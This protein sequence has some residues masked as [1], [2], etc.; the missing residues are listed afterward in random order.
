MKFWNMNAIIKRIMI[1][2]LLCTIIFL[3]ISTALAATQKSSDE[4]TAIQEQRIYEFAL[5]HHF[6]TI[7][8]KK[9][10]VG[11]PYQVNYNASGKYMAI[12]NTDNVDI[13][14]ISNGDKI[15]SVHDTSIQHAEFSPDA[16]YIN[17]TYRHWPMIRMWNVQTGQLMKELRWV[18]DLS[19]FCDATKACQG[20]EFMHT[21]SPDGRYAALVVDDYGLKIWSTNYTEPTKILFEFDITDLRFDITGEHLATLK[22][23]DYYWNRPGEISANIWNVKASKKVEQVTLP[24]NNYIILGYYAN[25]KKMIL[26][27]FERQNEFIEVWDVSSNIIEEF[28]PIDFKNDLIT[29]RYYLNTYFV[30]LIPFAVLTQAD[31]YSIVFI[32]PDANVIPFNDFDNAIKNTRYAR[33]WWRVKNRN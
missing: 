21:F 3:G 15:S 29:N 8:L 5:S 17:T 16:R 33:K 30:K 25:T 10:L 28:I 18:D 32:D 23:H 31:I 27:N 6:N 7:I 24:E 11:T 1:S 14:N 26:L 13:I 9:Q 20:K 12:I 19:H 22:K 4:I 2:M